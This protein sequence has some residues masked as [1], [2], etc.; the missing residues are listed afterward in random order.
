MALVAPSSGRATRH[1]R[2]RSPPFG[3]VRVDRQVRRAE[4]QLELDSYVNLSL[5]CRGYRPVDG[6][7]KTG[8]VGTRTSTMALPTCALASLGM[9]PVSLSGNPSG[10]PRSAGAP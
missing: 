6:A 4:P 9:S 7:V 1:G 8:A 5:P 2:A 10:R 3:G